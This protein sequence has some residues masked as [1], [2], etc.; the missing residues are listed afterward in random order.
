MRRAMLSFPPSYLYF[1]LFLSFSPS[2]VFWFSIRI[3]LACS[4]VKLRGHNPPLF[5]PGLAP[6][7]LSPFNL[8]ALFRSTGRAINVTGHHKAYRY[9]AK[10]R[11]GI[12]LAPPSERRERERRLRDN[13]QWKYRGTRGRFSRDERR[14][15][16]GEDY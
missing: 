8:L 5:G 7:S 3:T 15:T 12:T 1:S 4:Y 14:G 10:G 6:S 11:P 16:E 2:L 9:F 13:T